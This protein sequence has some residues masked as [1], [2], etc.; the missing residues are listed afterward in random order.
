MRGNVRNCVSFDKSVVIIVSHLHVT[1]ECSAWEGMRLQR[2]RHKCGRFRVKWCWIFSEHMRTHAHI[3]WS[4][5]RVIFCPTVK[6]DR[7]WT[8]PDDIRT[9][10]HVSLYSAVNNQCL[11]SF[12]NNRIN[13][14]NIQLNAVYIYFTEES[15]NYCQYFTLMT[16]WWNSLII[17]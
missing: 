1:L 8:S 2:G 10:L 16:N 14:I 4:V 3:S 6:F 13:P 9:S 15:I 17:H 11:Q 12:L 5:I 7:H